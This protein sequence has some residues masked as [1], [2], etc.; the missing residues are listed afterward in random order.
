MK[1]TLDSAFR[2]FY[3]IWSK[4][5]RSAATERSNLNWRVIIGSVARP[6]AQIDYSLLAPVFAAN[7]AGASVDDL[8][9]ACGLAKPTL[10]A[11]VGGHAELFRATVEA[12][13]ERLLERLRD[14]ADRTRYAGLRER[15]GALVVELADAAG[16]GAELVLV[17]APSAAAGRRLRTAIADGIGRGSDRADLIAGT[18][19]GAFAHTLVDGSELPVDA[20]VDLLTPA[21]IGD[22]APPAPSWGA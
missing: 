8:A 5:S 12:E 20:L 1:S 13:L 4:I 21:D 19:L 3:D 22:E 10:Y 6:R 15:I 14:A 16:P 18:M 7:G 2:G 11:R 17:T 9:R